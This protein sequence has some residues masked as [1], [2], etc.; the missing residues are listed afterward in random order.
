MTTQRHLVPLILVLPMLHLSC[1]RTVPTNQD[2]AQRGIPLDS[3]APSGFRA[4]EDHA[5]IVRTVAW[6]F[7]GKGKDAAAYYLDGKPVG[8]GDVALRKIFSLLVE[9]GCDVLIVEHGDGVGG[10]DAVLPFPC[11]PETLEII[12]GLFY[13]RLK[14]RIVQRVLVHVVDEKW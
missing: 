9:F 11:G 7:E 3:S 4:T 5:P 1:C 13:E 2:A 12:S 8:R 14:C 6:A 10:L